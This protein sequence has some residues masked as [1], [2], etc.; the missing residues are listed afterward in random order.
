MPEIDS[1]SEKQAATQAGL[2]RLFL[3]FEVVQFRWFWSSIFFSSMSVSVRLLTQ[4][5]LV[6]E[7]T[8]S[9]FWVG[10]VAGLQ[11]LGLLVFG[12]FSGTIRRS[13]KPSNQELLHPNLSDPELSKTADTQQSWTSP[14]YPL[15]WIQ[16]K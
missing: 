1:S 8:D 9:P 6:L 5:W 4:G 15:L 12:A 2:S 14:N 11:G 13:E 16:A 7:I 10:L 3:A